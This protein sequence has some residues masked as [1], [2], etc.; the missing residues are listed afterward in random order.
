MRLKEPAVKEA[1][2]VNTCDAAQPFRA[3]TSSLTSNVLNQRRA[4]T[5]RLQST[6]ARG[7]S[8]ALRG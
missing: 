8:A 5:R 7:P 2:P 4:A 3:S 1:A 6:A